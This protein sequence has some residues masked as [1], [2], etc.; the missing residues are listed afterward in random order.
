MTTPNGAEHALSLPHGAV[1]VVV[2]YHGPSAQQVEATY[3]VVDGVVP[4]ERRATAQALVGI[5]RLMMDEAREL[6]EQ[7]HEG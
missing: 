1:A 7:A 6:D 4:L 2:L 5:A 3:H